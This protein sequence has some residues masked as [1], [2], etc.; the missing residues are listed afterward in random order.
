[1]NQQEQ[2]LWPYGT[3]GALFA[4][5]IIW[6][7]MV[8]VL[9]T[10]R[11]YLGWPDDKSFNLAALIIIALGLIPI[12]FRLLDFAAS[13]RAVLDIK[14]VK[15]D[16]SRIDF[17]QPEVQRETSGIPDNIGV[18]GPIVSDTSPMNIIQTLKDA[19]KSE[20]V[21]IDLKEGDA[22]WVTR[23]L[24]L[25]AGAVRAGSPM[26][27]VFIGTKENH[28]HQFLGWAEPKPILDNIL[29]AKEE[30]DRRY[31]RALRIAQQVFI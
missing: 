28:S 2:P 3:R 15:I 21:V 16:F 12:A 13:R 22:W 29:R 26:A 10:M 30:Y 20:I 9:A 24:A 4:S 25:S 6:F 17:D 31:M 8:L 7:V 18:S 19:T 23:L 11:T 1:M 27:F 14:D 5:A